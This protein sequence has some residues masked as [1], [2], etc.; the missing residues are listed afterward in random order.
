[1]GLFRR[2][3]ILLKIPIAIK[4]INNSSQVPI[5]A[6]PD[7]ELFGALLFQTLKSSKGVWN[8]LLRV[9]N[10]SAMGNWNLDIHNSCDVHAKEESSPK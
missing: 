4:P 2:E 7:S 1:M 6:A 5:L 3:N 9:V 10:H 8:E